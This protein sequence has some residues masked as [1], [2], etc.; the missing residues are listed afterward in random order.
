MPKK[1]KKKVQSTDEELEIEVI[2][3]VEVIYEDTKVF[4]GI[5][6]EY[7]WG[8]IYWMITN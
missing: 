5:E 1:G 4:T 8:G 7:K 2:I 6:P 3:R